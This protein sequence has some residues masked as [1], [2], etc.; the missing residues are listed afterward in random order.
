MFNFSATFTDSYDIVTTVKIFNLEEFVGE[1]YGKRI[2]LNQD[3]FDSFR[4]RNI[5]L[6]H[7][8]RQKVVLKSLLNL[9]FVSICV[10]K[11]RELTGDDSLYHSPL[12][13][14]LVNTVNTKIEK[15]K[16]ICGLFS[17]T[18]G[19]RNWNIQLRYFFCR[20]E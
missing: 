14:T 9:A 16:M 18:S 13:L 11:I 5:E 6:T 8:E 7:N 12:M 17:D 10:G 2:Y 1:G 3:E 4:T 19:D 20:Q 15:E